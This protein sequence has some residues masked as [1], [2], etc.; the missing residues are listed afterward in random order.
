M[1]P[2]GPPNRSDT[3]LG[4]SSSAASGHRG[5]RTMD[6]SFSVCPQR[7]QCSF[8]GSWAALRFVLWQGKYLAFNL[9]IG[10]FSQPPF[11]EQTHRRL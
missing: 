10:R 6:L 2:L 8:T 4:T 3:A 5:L 1:M 11:L 9:V 7:A